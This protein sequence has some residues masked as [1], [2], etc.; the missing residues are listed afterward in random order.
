M[1]NSDFRLGKNYYLQM[2]LEE[3]KYVLKERPEYIT[4]DIEVSSDCDR[5]ESDEENS[6]KEN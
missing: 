1:I 2:F 6:N 4:K 3:C 5:E